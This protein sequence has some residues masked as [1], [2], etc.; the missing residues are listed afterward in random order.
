M[1]DFYIIIGHRSNKKQILLDVDDFFSF[2]FQKNTNL[3]I[4]FFGN[5]LYFEKKLSIKNG[6]DKFPPP[7]KKIWHPCMITDIF[8]S[9][10]HQA[11][12]TDDILLFHVTSQ[13][14]SFSTP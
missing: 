8:S 2:F 1:Y 6:V 7:K 4:L 14:V 9:L 11:Y 12:Y 10:L 5:I 3:F 13:I